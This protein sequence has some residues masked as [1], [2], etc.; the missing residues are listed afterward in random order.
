[1]VFPLSVY[2]IENVDNNDAAFSPLIF[3]LFTLTGTKCSQNT[4]CYYRWE[5]SSNNISRA[6]P[7]YDIDIWTKILTWKY[8]RL[9]MESSSNLLGTIFYYSRNTARSL[10][11]QGHWARHYVFGKRQLESYHRRQTQSA[12]YHKVSRF[13]KYELRKNPQHVN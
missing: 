4:L 6:R 10:L 1:M 2:V 5:K 7:I 13:N 8:C 11:A 9:I 3:I 12:A